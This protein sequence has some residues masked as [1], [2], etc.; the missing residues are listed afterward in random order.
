MPRKQKPIIVHLQVRSRDVQ[1]NFPEYN[2]NLVDPTPIQ[3]TSTIQYDLFTP[4]ENKPIKTGA[5][6]QVIECNSEYKDS[7]I[8]P[9][10][11][12]TVCWWD[13]HSFVT[14]PFFIP[15]A[16]IENQINQENSYSVYG[17]FC[18]P[19][20]ALAHLESEPSLDPEVRWERTMLLHEMCKRVYT[21]NNERISPSLPRWV[22]N[23]YGGG[24]TIDDFRKLN[25]KSTSDCE[26]VYPP[27]TV[28]IPILKVHNMDKTQT[29]TKK[30]IIQEERFKQA[31]NNINKNIKP[32]PEKKGILDLMNIRVE[33]MT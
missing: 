17:N 33:S 24:L 26:I 4:A 16:I 22:L 28:D 2:P 21:N 6:S 3:S 12:K 11:S 1:N 18:S 10:A 20:C 5:N 23:T 13:G 9:R 8:Y 31:E 27:I 32:Q 29:V 30:V 15:K 14:K 19:E 7:K 25:T